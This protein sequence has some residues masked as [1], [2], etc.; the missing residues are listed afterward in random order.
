MAPSNSDVSGQQKVREVLKEAANALRGS[1]GDK[2]DKIG[3]KSPRNSV[4][5][6]FHKPSFDM[7]I[8]GGDKDKDKGG[9]GWTSRNRRPSDDHGPVMRATTEDPD[10]PRVRDRLECVTQPCDI[11]WITF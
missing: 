8:F 4:K 11:N 1:S 6:H 3:T 2:S 10:I 5:R 7:N 9:N